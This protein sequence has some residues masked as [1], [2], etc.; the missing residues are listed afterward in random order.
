MSPTVRDR[1][2]LWLPAL[3]AAAVLLIAGSRDIFWNGDF[4]D[5]AGPAYVGL[6]RAGWATVMG[7]LPGYSGFIIVVGA[8]A[9]LLGEA[10]GWLDTAIFRLTALPGLAALAVLAVR[11]GGAARA[12]RAPGW[13]LV[14]ALAAGGPMGYQ[15][16][17]YGHP[18]DLLGASLA[19]LGVLAALDRRPTLASVLLLGAVVA[20][21]WAVLA[22]LPAVLATDRGRLRILLL[23]GLG[24][25]AVLSTQLF[26]IGGTAGTMVHT[27]TLFHPHQIYWPLGIDAPAAFTAAGHGELTAPAWLQGLTRPVLMGVAALLCAAWWVRERGRTA[28]REEVLVLLALVFALRCA[29]D[30]WNLVY[31]HLPLTLALLAW[32][33]RRGEP[34]PVLTLAVSL[35]AW[36]SFVTYDARSGMGPFLLYFA[37][38]APL[39]LHLGYR[40]LAAPKAAGAPA[41]PRVPAP[42]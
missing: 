34:W 20:K 30:P 14:I 4:I 31:Y 39:I 13:P 15:A 12:A 25:A 3:A 18:E 10:L 42:A 27:G 2:L 40:L 6:Q 16:L 38:M 8:P 36:I 33:V 9:A 5:E 19:V 23:A 21:Q 24:T 35:L 1:A 41:A 32:E 7:R 37:W 17:L 28:G 26:A 11:L 22:I 29:L